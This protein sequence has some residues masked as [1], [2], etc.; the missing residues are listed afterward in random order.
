MLSILRKAV[1]AV[2]HLLVILLKIVY[3][4]LA[5][6]KIRLLALYCI[7]CGILQLAYHPFSGENAAWFWVGIALC[8]LAT[9]FA[10]WR[11]FHKKQKRKEA[12][13]GR[14][15]ERTAREEPAQEELA[16]AEAPKPAPARYPRY[17]DAAGH[18][19]YIFAEYG[20][21]YELYHRE[22]NK[23]V[24]V[25]VDEKSTETKE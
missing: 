13:R 22:G 12:E 1:G 7:V 3:N 10:W 19:G 5:F 11:R 2:V 6:L 4:I 21:R 20:D 18:E 25:I 9:L 8:L 24:L 14:E 15:A 17:F 16:V 23:L